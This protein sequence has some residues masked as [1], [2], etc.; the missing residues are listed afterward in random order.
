M[1]PYGDGYV[2]RRGNRFWI[3][4]YADRDG[5]SK[6]IREGSWPTEVEAEKALKARAFA[7]QADRRGM[8]RF[9]TQAV[10]R[11]TLADIMEDWIKD[12]EARELKSIRTLRI[13]KATICRHLGHVRLTAI[14]GKH[15]G[16]YVATRKEAKASAA[17]IDRE[18]ETLRGG[19][20]LARRNGIIGWELPIRALS[21]RDANAR[22]GFVKPVDLQRLVAAIADPDLRDFIE[23]LGWT[24][25][26][27]G[28]IASLRWSEIHEET[29]VLRAADAKIGRSRIL[30]VW[31]P[32]VA[33]LQR[34]KA[35][36]VPG[37]DLI[38]HAAGGRAVRLQ[39][40][41]SKGWYGAWA[42]ALAAAGLPAGLIPY[43]L[44]RTAIR[45]M[46]RAGIP[47]LVQMQFSGHVTEST[48]RRYRIVDPEEMREALDRVAAARKA[49]IT[50]NTHT[51]KG[52]K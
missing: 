42:R 39:G 30:P 47:R 24:S 52:S 29:I 3:S 19:I 25:M 51:K 28:E 33:I 17:T 7:V 48:Y 11:M 26:R 22:Q 50:P 41:F 35:R 1:T 32:L 21:K 49:E 6:E 20:R 31:G 16:R 2:Y 14:T 4:Y 38:F 36:R 40:G 34:R 9:E 37:L 18:L 15:V 44:R 10:R 46:D 23:F 12:G 45:N 27:P 13:H 5:R 8:A 43:D